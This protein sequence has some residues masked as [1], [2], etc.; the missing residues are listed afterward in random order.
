MIKKIMF[1]L[2]LISIHSLTI[3]QEQYRIG[4]KAGA[5]FTGYHSGQ[6]AF[7][8]NFGFNLG[9]IAN[10]ELNEKLEL[11]AELLYSKKGG[12][13]KVFDN[14]GQFL[15]SIESNLDYIDLPVYVRVYVLKK[16][17]FE[18]GPQ[19]GFLLNSKGNI[20]DQKESLNFE[21]INT[22]DFSLN[23]GLSLDVNDELLIQARYGYGLYEVFENN[24]IKNSVISL[25][26]AYFFN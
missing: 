8:D 7:T 17:A 25:S 3:G 4:A 5:N 13:F 20:A 16:L 26:L 23:G 14:D 22:I 18:F 24:K 10:Y 6:S 1:T 12:I 2:I 11:G 9:A 19:V 21:N 15:T